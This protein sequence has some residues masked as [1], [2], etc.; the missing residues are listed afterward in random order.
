[1]GFAGVL[2]EIGLP[3]ENLI[4]ALLMFNLGVELGQVLFLLIVILLI[5]GLP[6]STHMDRTSLKRL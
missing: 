1:M 2:A 6:R 4:P 5:D 3:Q